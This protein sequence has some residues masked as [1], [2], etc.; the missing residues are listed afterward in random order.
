MKR[1]IEEVS[2]IYNEYCLGKSQKELDKKYNTDSYYLFK[3]HNLLSRKLGETKQLNRKNS[4]IYNYIFSNISNEIESYILGLWFADGWVTEHQAG[5]TLKNNDYKLLEKIKDYVC[6]DLTVKYNANTVKLIFS[7]TNLCENLKK[8]G[9]LN[10][11]TYKNY[12]FPN[13]P[14]NLQKDFIRGY[15]DGDGTV[16]LDKTR[17]KA[18]ICGINLNFLKEIEQILIINNIDC[19]INIEIRENKIYK[20]PQGFSNN[21]KNMYRLYVRKKQALEIFYSYMYS[22]STIYLNRK[23][24]KFKE[25]PEAKDMTPDKYQEYTK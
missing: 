11:K 20:T 1:T 15:F 22:N 9:C 17:P 12:V 7:N 19:K 5:I 3:K 2:K 21:C 24:D 23:K 4:L 6:P 14:I 13:I 25:L 8:L 18:N 16:Y 10:S